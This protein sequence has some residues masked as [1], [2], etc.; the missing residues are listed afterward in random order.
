MLNP[1]F[2]DYLLPTILDMPP[3][4]IEVLEHA[5]PAAPYGL[6]GVGEPPNISTP[7]RVAAALRDATGRAA[8]RGFR[9]VRSTSSI[10]ESELAVPGYHRAELS[11]ELTVVPSLDGDAPPRA[12]LEAAR[13]AAGASGL[14]HE[15]GPATML[16]AGERA[17]VLQ[18]TFKV[19]EA[20]LAAGAHIVQVKVEAQGDAGRFGGREARPEPAD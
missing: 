4:R 12:Q 14:A 9:C 15:S 1:S 18:S 17:A 2:T 5:D 3:M 13:A 7:P 6:K 8:G 11:A 19:I 20:S 10:L 16:L